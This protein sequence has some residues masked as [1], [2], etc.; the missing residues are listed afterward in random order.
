MPKKPA[1]HKNW[2]ST[3]NLLKIHRFSEQ[4]VMFWF[5]LLLKFDNRPSPLILT[6]TSN[7]VA[8]HSNEPM[9]GR[10]VKQVMIPVDHSCTLV[11]AIA[12]FWERSA[13]PG[14]HPL[15]SA[16]TFNQNKPKQP[17]TSLTMY[18][19]TFQS[20]TL[21]CITPLTVLIK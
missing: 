8:P 14:F 6:E 20:G 16:R 10:I 21:V 7:A 19:T 11:Y 3:E 12:N 15:P 18:S 4:V 5:N 2:P 9:N 17:D 13:R 1:S